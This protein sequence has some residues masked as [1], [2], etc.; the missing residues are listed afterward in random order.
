MWWAIH[1]SYRNDGSPPHTVCEKIVQCDTEPN[2][3]LATLV[4]C[5]KYMASRGDTLENEPE[6]RRQVTNNKALWCWEWIRKNNGDL[7]TVVEA[8]ETLEET[9]M[10][11]HTIDETDHRKDAYVT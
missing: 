1:V 3:R 4:L 11:L 8:P 2:A 10:M 7:F 9:V 5:K 6:C